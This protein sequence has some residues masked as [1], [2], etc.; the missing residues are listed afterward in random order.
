MQR[1]THVRQRPHVSDTLA[2]AVAANVT[3]PLLG[4]PFPSHLPS[5]PL[6]LRELVVMQ[7]NYRAISIRLPSPFPSRSFISLRP[8]LPLYRP[9]S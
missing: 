9:R 6:P 2:V 3:H 5:P 1:R 8:F 7:M 4:H